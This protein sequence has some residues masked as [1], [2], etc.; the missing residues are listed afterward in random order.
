MHPSIRRIACIPLLSI[1]LFSLSNA[2]GAVEGIGRGLVLTLPPDAA[3]PEPASA[4]VKPF[5]DWEG[6]KRDTWYFL[7]GQFLVLAVLYVGPEDLSGWSEEQKETYS[8]RRYRRNIGSITVDEDKWWVNYVLHPYWGGAYYVRARERGYGDDEAF[9]YSALLSTL[10]EYG[11]ES[12]FEQPSVQDLIFTPV[13]G[14]YV[15]GYFMDVR[16]RIRAR[17]AAGHEPG[18][19][20]RTLMVL[21]DPLGTMSG[22]IDGMLGFEGEVAVAPFFVAPAQVS[23]LHGGETVAGMQVLPGLQ[24]HLTW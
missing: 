12:L 18:V 23:A 7:G 9:W 8:F 4:E 6:L 5:R 2:I 1:L 22:L 3:A 14:Y 17:E 19:G 21:T 13:L 11:P 20:A 24:M 15:G 10:F 16:R